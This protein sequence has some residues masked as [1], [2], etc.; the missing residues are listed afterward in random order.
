MSY[1]RRMKRINYYLLAGLLALLL[2]SI[3]VSQLITRGQAEGVLRLEIYQDGDLVDTVV[4]AGEKTTSFKLYDQEGRYNQIE[5]KG[6][7]VR[8]VAAECRNQVCVHTGWIDQPGQMIVCAPH[9]LVLLLK[10]RAGEVDAI[11]Y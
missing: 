11:A 6:P 8:V 7:A 4:L 5:I 10:G 3:G 1:N 9:K 2:L